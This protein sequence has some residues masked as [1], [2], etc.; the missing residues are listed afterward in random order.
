MSKP[1]FRIIEGSSDSD[2]E[3]DYPRYKE[4][5]LACTI[6]VHDL[7]KKYTHIP[8]TTLMRW[9]KRALKE[10]DMTRRNSFR[11]ITY[12]NQYIVSRANGRYAIRK[13]MNGH[14]TWYGT[15]EDLETARMVRDKLHSCNFNEDVAKELMDKYSAERIPSPAYTYAMSKY[16]EWVKGYENP[17][18]TLNKLHEELGFN[19]CM[20]MHCIKRYREENPTAPRKR[21]VKFKTPVIKHYKNPM[22]HIKKQ[23][24]GKYMVLRTVNGQRK[25]YGTYDDL[26]TAVDVRERC[27][28]YDWLM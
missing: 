18:I 12:G 28:S 13:K 1:N 3:D 16:D 4:E 14:D 19:N 26:N 9:R 6:S 10:E 8:T 11:P 24:N 22:H 5:Y 23:S 2:Y 25:S 21:S 7:D 20:Y 17:Y 27:I 15:Y